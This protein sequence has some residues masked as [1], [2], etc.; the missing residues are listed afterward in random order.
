MPALPLVGSITPEQEGEA[1]NYLSGLIRESRYDRDDFTDLADNGKQMYLYGTLEWPTEKIVLNDIQNAIIAATDMQTREAPRPELQPVESDDIGISVP[2]GPAMLDQASGQLLPPAMVQI[3]DRVVAEVYQKVLERFWKR[4]E[5]DQWVRDNLLRTNT[6]GW[7]FTL[8][9]WEMPYGICLK[10]LS[11]HQVFIDPTVQRIKDAMYVGIAVVWDADEA[12]RKYPQLAEYIEGEQTKGTPK[13]PTNVT[14]LGDAQEQN[15]E[16]ETVTMLTFW[17]RRQ[18]MKMEIDQAVQSGAVEQREVVGEAWIQSQAIAGGEAQPPQHLPDVAGGEPDQGQDIL[19]DAAPELSDGSS[20]GPAAP[21]DSA[22]IAGNVPVPDAAG[23]LEQ[24]QSGYGADAIGPPPTRLAYFLPGGLDEIDPTSP[25]WPT[26]DGVRQISVLGNRIVEDAESPWGDIPILHNV[27]IPIPGKPWGIGE[28]FRLMKLQEGR[29]RI[30]DAMVTHADYYKHPV[31]VMPASMHSKMLK[32]Y[33]TAYISPKKTLVIDD[34][35]FMALGGK[36]DIFHDPPQINQSLIQL[37][38]LLKDDTNE[39]SGQTNAVRGIGDPGDSGRKTEFLAQQASTLIGFK[40]KRTQDLLERLTRLTL[41]M[42]KTLDVNAIGQI[43][44][45]YPPEALAVIV[46]R[47]N[48][49]MEW[50]VMVEVVAATGQTKA[51]KVEQAFRD[52]QAGAISMQTYR[53]IAGINHAQEDQ[54]MGMQM[55]QQLAAQAQ[56]E[57]VKGETSPNGDSAQPSPAAA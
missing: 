15:Y 17:L 56:Q 22:T 16:R 53:E 33:K 20:A 54:R 50:D 4:A 38:G 13:R 44:S 7:A 9:E 3:T 43:V 49:G 55:Q 32:E 18:P 40:A 14:F 37:H 35:D 24:G 27:C 57:A 23:L 31:A 36:V 28:P 41:E 6:E 10:D 30:T 26:R 51:A 29:S 21:G 34:A 1:V 12:K 39:Q 42:F 11:V 8:V 45:K 52:M 47:F 2:T 19:G 46:Q 5:A 48:S 25:D